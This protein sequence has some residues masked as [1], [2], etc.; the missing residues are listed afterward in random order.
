MGRLYLKM[1]LV[2]PVILHEL[3]S[4]DTKPS[5]TNYELRI[6]WSR[7]ALTHSAFSTVAS[8]VSNVG[9]A[10]ESDTSSRWHGVDTLPQLH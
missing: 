7:R 8:R 5:I 10:G 3:K 9:V 6:I 1:L 4:R 2:L